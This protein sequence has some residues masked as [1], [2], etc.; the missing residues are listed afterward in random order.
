[1]ADQDVLSRYRF[2]IEIVDHR[3]IYQQYY[4][5]KGLNVTQQDHINLDEWLNLDSP[6]C[7]H[8]LREAV[9]HYS[10]RCAKE[11][12]LEVCI[13]T[14]AMKEAAWKY[15]H[16]SQVILDGTFGMCNKKTLLML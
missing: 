7:N 10:A 12:R 11:E 16:C 15:A 2:F 4:R 3:S 1:M 8:K 5:L 9:F 13:M 6:Q 14:P